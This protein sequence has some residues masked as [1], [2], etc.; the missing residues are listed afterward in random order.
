MHCPT[1]D[2]TPRPIPTLPAETKA[3]TGGRDEDC[4]PSLLSS[5]TIGIIYDFSVSLIPIWTIQMCEEI[6]L[7][8]HILF[9]PD[10]VREAYPCGVPCVV[11]LGPLYFTV[12]FSSRGLS[13]DGGQRSL[14]SAACS[15]QNI[16]VGWGIP[17]LHHS[18]QHVLEYES[19]GAE[20]HCW[21]S[22]TRAC[23]T[24]SISPSSFL[25]CR[26]FHPD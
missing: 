23:S 19:Y 21:L 14:K 12:A 11:H 15:K 4:L 3:V 20:Y 22:K 18:L 8:A 16:V 2:P 26:Q 5:V 10:G 24:A 6:A 7:S 1:Y 9:H 17:R 25:G 13:V